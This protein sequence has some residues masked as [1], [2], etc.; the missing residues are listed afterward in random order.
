MKFTSKKERWPRSSILKLLLKYISLYSILKFFV[1]V[2]T[3]VF[4]YWAHCWYVTGR[5]LVADTNNS[6][7]R[8]ITLSEKGAEVRTLDLIGVQPP[9][10]K[11]KTLK[12]LRRRLSVDTDVINVDG[13]SSMEGFLSLAITV[14]DG[15]HFSKVNNIQRILFLLSC[16]TS[17]HYCW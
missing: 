15:Y 3:L 5:L 1:L 6:A 2:I 13:G 16:F 11:P 10:P 7:I 12:R 17:L 14:P 4:H 8:Y 9:S